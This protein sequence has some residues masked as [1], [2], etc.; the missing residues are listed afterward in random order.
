MMWT[1]GMADT[2]PENH[3]ASE[4]NSSNQMNNSTESGPTTEEAQN[5]VRNLSGNDNEEAP[6]QNNIDEDEESKTIC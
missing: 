6:Q 3:P 1:V 2:N 5:A 4:A